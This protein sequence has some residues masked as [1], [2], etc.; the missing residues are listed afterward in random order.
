MSKELLADMIAR[1][2]GIILDDALSSKCYEKFVEKRG[3]LDVDMLSADDLYEFAPY[4]TTNETYFFR[5]SAHF[6]LLDHLCVTKL[7][8]MDRKINVL[9]IACSIG[10]EAYSIAALFENFNFALKYAFD[11]SIDA[12]DINYKAIETAKKAHYSDRVLRE[13]GSKYLDILRDFIEVGANGFSVKNQLK[14][15]VNFFVH[16][17]FDG[18]WQKRYDIIFFRNA[19]IYFSDRSKAKALTIAAEALE[20]NGILIVG[21][22]E[23]QVVNSDDLVTRHEKETFF[24]EKTDA[25]EKKSAKNKQIKDIAIRRKHKK[26][27][28][29]DNTNSTDIFNPFLTVKYIAESIKDSAKDKDSINANIAYAVE[30]L[31]SDLDEADKAIKSLDKYGANAP[32]L[33]LRAEWFLAH[34][35]EEEALKLYKKTLEIDS[36]F[37]PANYRIGFIKNDA[38]NLQKALEL[39]NSSVHSGLEVFIGGFSTDDYRRAI[40]HKLQR[41]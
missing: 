22:G 12:F 1:K 4:F 11:Y 20:E 5:E 24:F 14:S 32:A 7:S 8:K 28:D 25:D 10:C 39:L 15:K 33:F 19:L 30:M 37:W 29:I 41:K 36:A 9:S 21:L 16:N 27:T 2:T 35:N 31:E 17:I 3:A 40:Q 6:N 34:K 13:D 26:I 18:L 38:K 23:T